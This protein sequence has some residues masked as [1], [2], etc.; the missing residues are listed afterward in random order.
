MANMA[1]SEAANDLKTIDNRASQHWSLKQILIKPSVYYYKEEWLVW[2]LQACEFMMTSTGHISGKIAHHCTQLQMTTSS[3]WWQVVG[4]GAGGLVRRRRSAMYLVQTRLLSAGI[5]RC[6]NAERHGCPAHSTRAVASDSAGGDN[7]DNTPGTCLETTDS[8]P[9]TYGY[10]VIIIIL[11]RFE[12][13][14]P[15]VT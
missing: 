9:A 2:Q 3:K 13:E 8:P 15:G 7:E 10:G 14:P 4:G 1:R 5:I 6:D 11:F 12:Y